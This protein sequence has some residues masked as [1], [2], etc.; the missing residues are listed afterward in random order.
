MVNIKI[1]N[2]P[3]KVEAGTTIIE[4]AKLIHIDIPHLCYHPDQTVKAHCRMCVV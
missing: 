4:A 1:N 2:I 3:L